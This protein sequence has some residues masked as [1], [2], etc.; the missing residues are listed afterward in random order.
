MVG[1]K[2]KCNEKRKLLNF[3]VAGGID[4]NNGGN[5]NGGHPPEGG[6]QSNAQERGLGGPQHGNTAQ[7]GAGNPEEA[8]APE[9]EN[10]GR[11]SQAEVGGAEARGKSFS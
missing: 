3:G 7:D 4:S 10:A 11:P 6:A 5:G 8:N 2:F 1:L 9:G